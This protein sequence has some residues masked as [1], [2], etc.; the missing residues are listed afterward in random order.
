[1]LL[2]RA[3][4]VISAAA[5]GY[6]ILLMRFLSIIQWHHFASLIISLALLGCGASGIFLALTQPRVA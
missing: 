5:I 3:I 4:S 2:C 1:M 6:E